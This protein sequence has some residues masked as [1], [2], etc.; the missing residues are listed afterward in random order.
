[1]PDYLRLRTVEC[2]N[3]LVVRLDGSRLCLVKSQRPGDLPSAKERFCSLCEHVHAIFS[4]IS[5]VL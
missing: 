5:Y 3:S 4:T 2:A 1:M